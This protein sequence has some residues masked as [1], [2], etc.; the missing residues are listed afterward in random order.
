MPSNYENREDNNRFKV[1]GGDLAG[2]RK[3]C[4]KGRGIKAVYQKR[5]FP[6]T[7]RRLATIWLNG[8]VKNLPREK[9]CTD[10]KECSSTRPQG[11]VTG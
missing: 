7:R 4:P 9:T 3:N 1:T 8:Q 2:E 5:P 6:F 10:I 11:P